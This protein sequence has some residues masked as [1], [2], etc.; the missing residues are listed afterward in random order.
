MPVLL[1]LP[2]CCLFVAAANLA[3]S[4]EPNRTAFDDYIERPDPAFAWKV[5]KTTAAN[6]VQT[7]IIQLTS[8]RWLT[9]KEVDRPLWEHWVV[10]VTPAKV[11]S[12]IAF[13][14]V[15]GGSN[16]RPMPDK[17][18]P[19]VMKMAEETGSIAIELR[20]IPN[21]PL[22]FHQDGQPRKEDDL[23]GYAWDQFLKSGDPVWLPRFPMVKSVVRCMDCIQ[24]WSTEIGHPVEKFVVAGGSKR[25]WTT[26][27]TGV[28]DKRLAA[29]VPVVIDV[30][31]AKPS[32]Q[33]HAEVY[34]F[35]AN[36]IGNYYQHQ[37][38]QRPDHPR[39]DEIY[40][41]VDPFSYRDRLTM[42]KYVINASGDQF[43]CPDS[44]QFYYDDLPGEKLL[45]Y[46]PNA[47][48]SLRASDG[49]E[50]MIAYFQLLTTDRPRPEYSW[51]F[52][53]DGIIRIR[54][55]TPA[56]KVTVWQ[57]TNPKAR[58][59]RIESIGPAFQSRELQ[60][61][62]DGTY[63][64]RMYSPKEGWTACFAELS[65]ESGG[66]FPLKVSTAIRILPD[67][68]PFPQID[69]KTVPFEGLLKK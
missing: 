23:I 39:M 49:A 19:I 50:G 64:V 2:L 15:G 61:E 43:F 1:R 60:P 13:L 25:G 24:A 4:A 28:A 38:L 34:G 69:P 51:Q 45:R 32:I 12:N 30:V 16:D 11:T 6:S 42:P 8:Q 27:M 7:T 53:E 40:K 52:E 18:D 21:Q 65:Y 62:A 20:T 58:D 59:F 9:E 68:V 3:M 31:N 66:S 37:I 54:S 17:A 48:H 47:D 41:L 14:F 67:R 26:W 33:H 5:V 57:A 56:Q 10:V 22:T 44:S 35:W 63:V 36:A 29:I 55:V 46:V